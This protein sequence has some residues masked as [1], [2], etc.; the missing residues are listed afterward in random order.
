MTSGMRSNGSREIFFCWCYHCCAIP[1]EACIVQLSL[2]AYWWFRTVSIG[3]LRACCTFNINTL[4]FAKIT[5]IFWAIYFQL[6]RTFFSLC[7]FS[8]YRLILKRSIRTNFLSTT[9][10]TRFLRLLSRKIV[11]AIILRRVPSAN[12]NG[13]CLNRMKDFHL[14]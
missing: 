11:T 10:I 3:N 9:T 8:D 6:S 5:A 14:S 7:P 2:K 4:S 13:K 1:I 12:V